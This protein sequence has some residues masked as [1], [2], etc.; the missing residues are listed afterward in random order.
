[1][2]NHHLPW[3]LLAIF[4]CGWQGVPAQSAASGPLRFGLAGGLNFNLHTA[5]FVA[6]PNVESCCPQFE[7]GSGL[8][9]SLSF[10]AEVQ[11]TSSIFAG[12][13]FGY[14]SLNGKL[15]ALEN[16]VV[17][18]DDDKGEPIAPSLE[19][20]S[21]EH[22]IDAGL[23]GIAIELSG[24]LNL[25][26]ALYAYAGV[27]GD[28]LIRQTFSQKETLLQ[29]EWGSFE[30]GSRIRNEQSGPIPAASDVTTSLLLGF[31]Y[32]TNLN[33]EGT[34]LA[35]PEVGIV[36]GLSDY[37]RGLDWRSTTLRFGVAL[38]YAPKAS[39]LT[40]ASGTG[41]A[42][43]V[44]SLDEVEAGEP[45]LNA[46]LP[47]RVVDERGRERAAQSIQVR[48]FVRR[49]LTPLLPYLFFAK[50]ES[51]IPDRYLD[52]DPATMQGS[53]E[54]GDRGSSNALAVYYRL[55]DIIGRR[56]QRHPQ[57]TLTLSAYRARDEEESSERLTRQRAQA[58]ESYLRDAWQIA[59]GRL[60]LVSADL[61]PRPSPSDTEDG[62]AENRRVEITSDHP[63]ILAPLPWRDT[64][65]DCRPATLRLRPLVQGRAAVASWQLRFQG[66]ERL[67]ASLGGS[68]APPPSVD[69]SI[70]ANIERFPSGL[71][72]LAAELLLRQ[73]DGRTLALSATS[74]PLHWQNGSQDPG[75][76]RHPGYL[77]L[78]DVLLFDYNSAELSPQSKA[79]LAL[80][81]PRIDSSASV[82]IDGY[83]DRS[84][85]EDYNRRLATSRARNCAAQL[86]RRDAGVAGHGEHSQRYTNE[87]PEG[88][89]YNR[90]V[91]IRV[92]SL[93]EAHGD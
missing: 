12:L 34:L 3:L 28:V 40:L 51:R 15:T 47:L 45:A 6:L 79:L 75:D 59:P 56:L 43:A 26:P 46:L 52:A 82:H 17:V 77:G 53:A 37:V 57:A 2:R 83:C 64:I 68:A 16:S 25:A 88:R 89:F 10:L 81:R 44:R 73:D 39:T 70:A 92:E 91:S 50:G 60:R 22:S 33:A 38:K 24:G 36:W 93:V 72:S 85:N 55:L 14:T 63:A 8:G 21:I 13:R 84:G 48:R 41:S 61:P 4:M 23:Q 30:N 9:A 31:G 11:I 66:A 18:A 74:I 69:W 90:A 65:F 1:M 67:I 54:P 27:R 20:L 5:N 19:G 71:D 86:N 58:V 32:A 49:G 87:L 7:G 42:A 76:S 62:R 78:Y 35:V 80:I 29:P